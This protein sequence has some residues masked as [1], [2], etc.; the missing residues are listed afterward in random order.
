MN[1]CKGC[2]FVMAINV[3]CK[4]EVCK[5]CIEKGIYPMTYTIKKGKKRE[6][7]IMRTIRSYRWYLERLAAL[8]YT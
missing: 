6:G 5:S 2:G 7:I 1:V 3:E 4:D 8:R